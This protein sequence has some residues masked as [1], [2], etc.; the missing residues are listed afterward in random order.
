MK[1]KSMTDTIL[2]KKILLTCL[3]A[4]RGIHLAPEL[5]LAPIVTGWTGNDPIDDSELAFILYKMRIRR[6]RVT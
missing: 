3:T 4:L 1:Y 6:R 2:G 5:D